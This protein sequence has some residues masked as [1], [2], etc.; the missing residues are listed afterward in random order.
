MHSSNTG[1]PKAVDYPAAIVTHPPA[2]EAELD[3]Q[4]IAI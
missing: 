4:P 1:F 2:Y 3:Q